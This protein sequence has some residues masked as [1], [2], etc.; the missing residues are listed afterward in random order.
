MWCSTPYHIS[1]A[2]ETFWLKAR[3]SPL[4]GCDAYFLF[5]SLRA[6]GCFLAEVIKHSHLNL[7]SLYVLYGIQQ[8]QQRQVKGFIHLWHLLNYFIC[9]VQ[10]GECYNYS[11]IFIRLH[12]QYKIPQ[13]KM[14]YTNGWFF[15]LLLLSGD[16]LS[17]IVQSIISLY[18]CWP[19]SRPSGKLLKVVSKAWSIP[20]PNKNT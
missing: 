15:P 10:I 17:S 11:T 19:S 13:I 14:E 5:S 3:W 6:T 4:L 9:L 18:R 16:K 2:H 1:T 12:C 20:M 7:W 8:N